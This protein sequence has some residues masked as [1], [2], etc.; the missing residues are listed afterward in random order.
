MMGIYPPFGVAPSRVAPSHGRVQR[1]EKGSQRQQR[2]QLRPSS[3]SYVRLPS[4]AL[5]Q[6]GGYNSN[7]SPNQA[8]NLSHSTVHKV[9]ST[10]PNSVSG[11]FAY[12]A[13]ADGTTITWY[14]DGSNS[15]NPIVI[16]RSDGSNFTV[17]SAGSGLAVSGLTA[18]TTYYFLPFWNTLSNT[19]IGWVPAGLGSPS[20]A[21]TQGNTVGPFANY[22]IMSQNLQHLEPLSGGFMSAVTG[23]GSHGGGGGGGG[24]GGNGHCVMSGTEIET[25]GELPYVVKSYDEFT[26]LHIV[27]EDDNWLNCTT[28]HP[29]Y[30]ASEGRVNASDLAEGDLVITKRGEREIVQIKSLHKKWLK[31]EVLMEKGHLYWA[32]GFLSHNVKIP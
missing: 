8:I 5:I 26:W 15:S 9:G 27:D 4:S 30:H 7:L 1:L 14:W 10:P 13:S 16:H 11:N 25:L 3:G 22:Y 20:I 19:N 31:N 17:P 18:S 23:D 28:D 6:N 24:G 21:F 2:G 12:V 29:L 32:N